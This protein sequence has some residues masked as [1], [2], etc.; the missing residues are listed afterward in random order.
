MKCIK[1]V[2]N[3]KNYTVGTTLRVTDGEAD[4]KVRSGYYTYISKSEWKN[5][6]KADA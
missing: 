3:S 6:P 5:K 4:L 1:A 2:K